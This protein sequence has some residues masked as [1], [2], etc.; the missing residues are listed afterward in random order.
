MFAVIPRRIGRYNPLK[1]AGEK[2]P[3]R[4]WRERF[5]SRARLP[6]IVLAGMVAQGEWRL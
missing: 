3:C 2:L 4:E 5:Y 6:R 1:F